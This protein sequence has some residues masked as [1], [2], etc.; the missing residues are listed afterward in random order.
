MVVELSLRGRDVCGTLQEEGTWEGTVEAETQ[1]ATSQVRVRLGTQRLQWPGAERFAT[2]QQ[3]VIRMQV[4][5]EATDRRR[6]EIEDL[7]NDLF[8]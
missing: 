1:T 5:P 4:N 6:R 2:D 8:G 3:V 7:V